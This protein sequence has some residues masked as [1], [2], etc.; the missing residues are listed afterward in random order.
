[1][2]SKVCNKCHIDKIVSEFY[3]RKSQN[4]YCSVCKFCEKENSLRYHHAHKEAINKKHEIWK[5]NNK[6]QMAKT[7]KDYR[8]KNKDLIKIRK[9]KYRINNLEKERKRERKYRTE[10]EKKDSLYKLKKRIRNAVDK[11]FR[12]NNTPK[13]SSTAK[14]LGCTFEEFK[15][16]LEKQFESWM[17]WNNYG[18]Y[19]FEGE[20][21][22]QIDHIIPISLA[23]TEEDVIRLN[24]YTNLR[25]LCS[26][27]NL[28]K[29]NKF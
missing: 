24:H 26:K 23:K 3:F 15:I 16:Q 12:R 28:D 19:K 2:E 21:T 1:M 27:E 22:W 7:S 13:S 9:R 25:P 6:E 5:S 17:N 11:S 20:R 29:S 10:R 4:R 14:I 18:V 8:E